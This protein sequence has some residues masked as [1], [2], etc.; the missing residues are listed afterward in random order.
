VTLENE[1]VLRSVARIH[2]ETGVPISTHTHARTERGLDQQHIFAEEGVDL[3]RVIIGHSG[4]TADLAYLER[5]ID[6]GSY[7]GMDRFGIDVLLPFEER[8]NTVAALCGRGYADRMVLSQDYAVFMDILPWEAVP[9]LLPRWSYLHIHRDVLPALRE[10]G[11]TEEQIEQML[12]ANP[13][14]IFEAQGGY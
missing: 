4:D 9:Q 1:R 10:R 14:A 7:L 12:V 5:L 11:V 8:V 2:R 3:G 13:R 6:A